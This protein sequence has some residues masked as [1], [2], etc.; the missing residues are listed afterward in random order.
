MGAVAAFARH[1]HH[2]G[3]DNRRL[4][5]AR[6]K[7]SAMLLVIRSDLLGLRTINGIEWRA[8]LQDFGDIAGAGEAGLLAAFD[9]AAA[10]VRAE[11]DILL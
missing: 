10:D 4:N 3:A 9:R 2:W 6:W 7:K 8:A 11:D 1:R 5:R